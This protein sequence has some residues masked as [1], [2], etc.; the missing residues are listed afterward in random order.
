MS[1][2]KKSRKPGTGSASVPKAKESKAE[3]AQAAPRKPKKTTGKPA[4]HRQKEAIAKKTAQ[5]NTAKNKDPRIG[6]KTPIVLG[7]KTTANKAPVVKTN[8]ATT[9]QQSESPIAAIRSVEPINNIPQEIEKIE[10]DPILLAIVDKQDTN[11][12]L[13]TEE[14]DYYNTQMERHQAL[15]DELDEGEEEELIH[16][17]SASIDEG[18]L[19]DKLDNSDLSKFE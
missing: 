9:S 14:V 18:E 6:N 10:N 17:P 13:T 19:W 8:K 3:L 1:R 4:G 11:E 12:A 16:S 15:S 2:T 5:E 7:A